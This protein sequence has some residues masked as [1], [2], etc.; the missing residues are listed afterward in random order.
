[1]I[2]E[3]RF[4]LVVADIA[5]E[6]FSEIVCLI[7]RRAGEMAM[8]VILVTAQEEPLTAAVYYGTE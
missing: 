2:P 6:C 3:A 1:M 5:N 8:N 7:V 4:G